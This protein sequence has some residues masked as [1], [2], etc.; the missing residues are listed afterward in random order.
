MYSTPNNTTSQAF[1]FYSFD[2]CQSPSSSPTQDR[3][4]RNK[5][6]IRSFPILCRLPNSHTETE[7]KQTQPTSDV[8]FIPM[9]KL[10]QFLLN[11]P[12]WLVW[13]QHAFGK[14]PSC[15]RRRR[16]SV[17]GS[18]ELLLGF[19]SFRSSSEQKLTTSGS[20]GIQAGRPR[21]ANGHL[22]QLNFTPMS[23]KATFFACRSIEWQQNWSPVFLGAEGSARSLF[24]RKLSASQQILQWHWLWRSRIVT[25]YDCEQASEFQ[26]FEFSLACWDLTDDANGRHYENR[27]I[28]SN[29]Q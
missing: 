9:E 25:K 7:S 2:C 16:Q 8:N 13:W 6:S 21:Q 22:K 28:C 26:H 15:R 24:I 1:D 19:Y 5:L 4:V 29:S 11:D 12:G 17:R 10:N 14:D 23:V 18:L 3:E 27:S 20:R